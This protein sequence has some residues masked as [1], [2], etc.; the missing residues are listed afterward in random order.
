MFFHDF[1][2]SK[3]PCCCETNVKAA[4]INSI[5]LFV[6][7]F[8]AFL[9]ID[10]V[11]I[12]IGVS[13]VL[14]SA[15]SIYGAYSQKN[16]IILIWIIIACIEFMDLIALAVW[17]SIQLINLGVPWQKLFTAWFTDAYTVGLITR[18]IFLGWAINVGINARKE[19]KM[20]KRIINVAMRQD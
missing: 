8:T 5:I 11:S 1:S 19:I 10:T 13:S 16:T 15:L 3:M 2:L 6:L 20:E 14:I 9:Y 12:I 17:L 7:S 18:I 4:Q